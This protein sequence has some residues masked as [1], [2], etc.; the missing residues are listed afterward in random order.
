MEDSEEKIEYRLSG[1]SPVELTTSFSSPNKNKNY[2]VCPTIKLPIFDEIIL[3]LPEQEIEGITLVTGD[4]T[5]QNKTTA[6]VTCEYKNVI[7][8]TKK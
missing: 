4:A 3:A 1:S 7:P 5:V 6:L 2:C 8:W